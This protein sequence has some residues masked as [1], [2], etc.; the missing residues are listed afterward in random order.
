[1]V[2]VLCWCLR[3]SSGNTQTVLSHNCCHH[4]SLYF[5][6][7]WTQPALELSVSLWSFFGNNSQHFIYNLRARSIPYCGRCL[8]SE[9][10]LFSVSAHGRR[11]RKVGM[12]CVDGSVSGVPLRLQCKLTSVF[13]S[14]ASGWSL[15]MTQ[16]VLQPDV[17]GKYSFWLGSFPILRF[18]GTEA[19]SN[20]RHLHE[21]LSSKCLRVFNWSNR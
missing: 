12:Q 8:H 15:F 14:F 4:L 6:V 17:W 19:Q 21:Y 13:K 7:L 2:G 3:G 9:Y 1:M 5:T 11:E 16:Q 20:V 10:T 18:W